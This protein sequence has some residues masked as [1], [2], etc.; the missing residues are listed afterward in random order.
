MVLSEAGDHPMTK[1]SDTQAIILSA[2]SQRDDGAVL[3]RAEFS[4]LIT[5]EK[6]LAERLAESGVRLPAVCG[7]R[8]RM[9]PSSLAPASW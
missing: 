1:L 4:D 5:R 2:A 8:A 3:P 6:I 9:L 7:H